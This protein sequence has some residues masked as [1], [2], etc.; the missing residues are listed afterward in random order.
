MERKQISLEQL[1]DIYAFRIVV[2][3]VRGL[4]PRARRRAHHLARRARPL[5]GLHLEPQAERLSV[6]PHHHRR[7]AP[8]ARRAADPHRAHALDRRI[9]RGGARALQGRQRLERA[10]GHRAEPGH[11]CLSLAAP[12]RRHAARRRQPRGVP[13][14]HQARAVPG[15][16][17]LLHAEGPA[18]RAAARRQPDRLRLCGAHRHRQHLRRRQDQRPP[19]AARH[20]AQERR[21][22]RDRLLEG[23]APALGLAEPRRH[24]QGA[25]GHQAR[26]P[27]RR[28][29]P[30]R[31]ARP[32]DPGARLPAPRQDLQRG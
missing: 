23:A 10:N 29:R 16:G 20:R 31:Q 11:Q 2:P 3:E 4:L 15:P 21:R 24:R 26:D 22:G 17:V 9:W 25:L 7:P 8:S 5:Q 27:R 30:I 28:A 13:R 18:D 19:D 14:A 12:S 1:S 6:D 32:R